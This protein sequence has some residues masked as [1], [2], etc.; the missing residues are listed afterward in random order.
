MISAASVCH[1]ITTLLTAS[2][3]RVTLRFLYYL[4]QRCLIR[5]LTSKVLLNVPGQ[6]ITNFNRYLRIRRCLRFERQAH[7]RLSYTTRSITSIELR[8]RK[9]SLLSLNGLRPMIILDHR[10]MRYFSCSNN[11]GR[12][13]S[14][15]SNAVTQR[16]FLVLGLTRSSNAFVVWKN[17]I[18]VY[19]I[20]SLLYFDVSDALLSQLFSIV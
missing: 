1:P 16:C 13:R 20:L 2:L 19:E 18:T 7:R 12:N 3:C 17:Y 8:N 4:L 15:N 9:I 6:I 10:S 5:S 14:S 11:N